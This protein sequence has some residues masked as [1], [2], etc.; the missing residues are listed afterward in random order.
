MFVGINRVISLMLLAL[1]GCGGGGD[2]SDGG[3]NTTTSIPEF[4]LQCDLNAGYTAAIPPLSYPTA[5][6]YVATVIIVHGKNGSPTRAHLQTLKDDLNAQGYDVILPQMPWHG[7]TWDGTLCEGITHLN[8]LI[9]TEKD[10]GKPVILLGHSLAGPIVLGYSALTDT[11]KPDA[12]TVLAPG[13]FIHQ[14]SILAD[15]H[16]PSIQSAKDKIAVGMGDVIATFQTSNNGLVNISTTANIYLSF[17]DT[18]KFPDIAASLP[19][20]AE[21]ML[22]LAGADDRL[23]AVADDILGIVALIPSVPTTN[24]YRVIPGDHFTVVNNVT[25]ELHPWYQGL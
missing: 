5:N 10:L 14:S 13:H 23:T 21:P 19:L 2:S 12:V 20:V 17:H 24:S 25:A 22:W 16:A 1:V 6:T 18:S 15:L 7:L 3:S 11:T 8:D 9:T 4:N